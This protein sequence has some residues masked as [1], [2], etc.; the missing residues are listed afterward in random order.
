MN[1]VSNPQASY[2]AL[3]ADGHPLPS[4]ERVQELLFDAARLGRTDVI[5]A[6]L[7]AGADLTARDPR[8]YTALILASYNGHAEATRLLLEHGAGVDHPDTGRGNT[9]LM[10]VAFKGYQDISEILLAAG[11]DPNALNKAGQSALMMAA[12]FGHVEIVKRLL[13]LRADPHLKDAAGNSATSVAEMQ[14]NSAVLEALR[15]A[16]AASV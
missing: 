16:P 13:A 8:G 6:L 9:A 5:P 10:G 7:H 14:G 2:E 1:S 3:P 12:L 15:S 11:A 4:P